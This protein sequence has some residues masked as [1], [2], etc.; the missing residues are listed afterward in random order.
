MSKTVTTIVMS[1]ALAGAALPAAASAQ[2][3]VRPGAAAGAAV[4]ALPAPGSWATGWSA[5]ISDTRAPTVKYL[6]LISPTGERKPVGT[7]AAGTTVLDVRHDARMIITR[8][9]VV[10]GTPTVFTLWDA[11][12]AT[13]RRINVPAGQGLD[14]GPGDQL[15]A[16]E[17]YPNPRV[18]VRSKEGAVVR[19]LSVPTDGQ[20]AVSPGG[21]TY[22]V[23]RGNDI[24]IYDVVANRLVRAI[25]NQNP[26]VSC[27][28]LGLWSDGQMRFGC[29]DIPGNSAVYKASA[30]TGAVTH[31]AGVVSDAGTV[32][33]TNPIAAQTFWSDSCQGGGTALVKDGKPVWVNPTGPWG[34]GTHNVRTVAGS[35]TSLWMTVGWTCAED[36]QKTSLARYNTS[37]GAV[38]VLAGPG[39]P[40]DQGTVRSA[41]SVDGLT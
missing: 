38:T 15:I 23:S 21:T 35:G 5:V 31:L 24:G 40:G 14:F 39:S 2:A 22:M 1:L 30:S 26:G 3:S 6:A 28:A 16:Q 11:A 10:E 4:P 41:Q 20:P 29:Y 27:T 9:K 17:G 8:S 34:A 37:T 33:A 18:T 36:N 19:T 7:V 32:F 12:T 25:P 13:G